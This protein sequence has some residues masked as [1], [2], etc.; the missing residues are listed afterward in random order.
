M[1]D[2]PLSSHLVDGNRRYPD[3]PEPSWYTGQS[4]TPSAAGNAY[5]SGIHERPSGAFRLPGPGETGYAPADP[6]S[7]TGSHAFPVTDGSRQDQ[8]RVTPRGPEYPAVRPT[9]GA[10]SLADAPQPAT[11]GGKRGGNP[12]DEPTSMVPPVN[13][14]GR[15]R[16]YRT[17]R[18]LSA[19]L[20]TAVTAV[21]MIPAIMLLI[22]ATFGDGPMAPGGVVPAVLL[23]F[24][25]LLTGGGLFALG[26]G[27]P[28]TREAWLRLPLAYLP[29][30]LILLLAAGL[31]AA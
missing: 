21:L 9:S 28:P 6:V 22:D 30:G 16:M 31:G 12:Y 13:R 14:G 3:E 1:R 23:T 8:T 5:D 19:M 27:Q 4:A 7:S 26:G 2:G 25:L 15:E 18:P 24:G 17:R 20:I 29:I 10:T 11:Y